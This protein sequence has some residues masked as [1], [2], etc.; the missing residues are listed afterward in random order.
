MRF[1][2]RAM[3]SLLFKPFSLLSLDALCAV[4]L[5]TCSVLVG[6]LLTHI[7]AWLWSSVFY[8][9][10]IY[11]FPLPLYFF[12]SKNNVE[13]TKNFKAKKEAFSTSCFKFIQQKVDGSTYLLFI[14][15]S[16]THWNCMRCNLWVP[17][18]RFEY[19]SKDSAVWIADGFRLLKKLNI[20]MGIP[21]TKWNQRSE[22]TS[23]QKRTG[24]SPTRAMQKTPPLQQG[25]RMCEHSC[26]K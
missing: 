6:L 22:T 13:P 7:S 14:F 24:W 17:P 11:F 19:L 9:N 26:V 8:M 3:I 2:C 18:P 21:G 12:H 25:Q 16:A 4:T 15:Y 1:T 10:N 23:R 20:F 5:S